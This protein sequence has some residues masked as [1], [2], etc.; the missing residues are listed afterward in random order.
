MSYRAR[1]AI[2]EQIKQE[3]ARTAQSSQEYERR[4]KALANKL[5]I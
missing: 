5:K 3:I 1:L 4:I 2:Y